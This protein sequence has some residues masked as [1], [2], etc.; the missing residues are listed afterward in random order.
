MFKLNPEVMN[1][2][3]GRLKHN[4]EMAK[5]LKELILHTIYDTKEAE[6]DLGKFWYLGGNSMSLLCRLSAVDESYRKTWDEVKNSKNSFNDL[7]LAGA[8]FNGMDLSGS[9]FNGSI[10]D[11]A[12]FSFTQL[13]DVEFEE[14]SLENI[15]CDEIGDVSTC[16]FL[17]IVPLKVVVG[18]KAGEVL[19]YCKEKHLNKIL[20]AHSEEVNDVCILDNRWI[21]S[22]SNDKNI[23]MYDGGGNDVAER[24]IIPLLSNVQ[25][26]DTVD[27][28]CYAGTGNQGVY[29]VDK[30]S[31]EGEIIS[32]PVIDDNANYIK[33]LRVF[34]HNAETYLVTAFESGKITIINVSHAEDKGKLPL[35]NMHVDIP[36]VV[37]SKDIGK[38]TDMCVTGNHIVYI[39]DKAIY[40]IPCSGLDVMNL[41]EHKCKEL[42]GAEYIIYAKD[43][44]RVYCLFKTGENYR[45][46]KILTSPATNDFWDFQ[47]LELT[48]P[49]DIA[50]ING[51]AVSDN[52]EHIAFVGDY[53]GIKNRLWISSRNNESTSGR[54][55]TTTA[56][57]NIDCKNLK[58]K[59]CKGLSAKTQK[60]FE[61]KKVKIE[62]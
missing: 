26:L 32:C 33:L 34:T 17:S 39:N 38:I 18:T 35:E 44:E 20:T 19:V 16:D 56:E 54:K 14:A 1:S 60:F 50:K 48:I 25:A 37:S 61:N 40:A 8:N 12:D 28:V 7:N 57:F 55:T 41:H 4:Q 53:D 31:T 62:I 10:L 45:R 13:R 58:I 36:M 42:D 9:K 51:F 43:E 23:L 24:G 49:T 59:K 21:F 22:A 6:G 46:Y 15:K 47:E 52:G 3:Y 5:G 30:N 29:R 2:L 11:E 27:D